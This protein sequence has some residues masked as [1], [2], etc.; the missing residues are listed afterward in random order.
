MALALDD[1]LPFYPE[2]DD[3]LLQRTLWQKKEFHDFRVGQMEQKIEGKRKLDQQVLTERFFSDVA[4]Y[5]EGLIYHE[6]GTGKTWSAFALAESL[7]QRKNFKQCI[8]LARGDDSL[9]NLRR[10]LVTTGNSTYVLATDKRTMEEEMRQIRRIVKDFYVF[11]TYYAFGKELS[12]MPDDTIK[13]KY[14]NT[15]FVIDEVHN[16]RPA[17]NSAIYK[18][19]H[20][21]FHLV[22]RRKILLMS[23]T[24]MRDD[25]GEIADIMNLILPEDKQL[26][27]GALFRAEFLEEQKDGTFMPRKEKIS[28]LKE[29][30]RG[31]ISYMSSALTNVAI[32][33]EGVSELPDIPQFRS[34]D[35]RMSKHQSDAYQNAYS[36]DTKGEERSIYTN[37]LQASLFVFPDGSWGTEGTGTFMKENGTLREDFAEQLRTNLQD[38]SAKYH[39]IIQT[40]KNP[41]NRHKNVYIYCS[42]VN[43]S[44][45]NLLA[46]ILELYGYRRCE[47]TEQGKARRYLLLTSQTKN[48]TRKIAYFNREQN[49]NG[50]YCHVIVGSRKIAEVFSF[51]NVQIE[52]LETLHWNETETSQASRRAARVGSWDALLAVTPNVSLS[53]SKVCA[54]P[55]KDSDVSID[56]LMLEI[57]KR[58]DISIKRIDRIIK[59]V[60][61]DCPLMYER[62]VHLESGDYSR[63]CD[64][65]V[66]VYKCDAG[67]CG[68]NGPETGGQDFST[69]ELYYDDYFGLIDPI[70][71]LFEQ[72]DSL[73][74]QALTDIVRPVEHIQILKALTFIIENNLVILNR[75]KT[76][77]YLR[78]R[79]DLYYLVTSLTSNVSSLEHPVFTREESLDGF[80][81]ELSRAKSVD[82]LKELRNG[83]D[84]TAALNQLPGSTA[85]LLVQLAIKESLLNNN[86]SQQV[87]KVLTHYDKSF[88][89]YRSVQ[90]YLAIF[91]DHNEVTWCLKPD[92]EWALCVAQI[93]RQAPPSDSQVGYEGILGEEGKFCIRST[94]QDEKM[95]DKR[96]LKTGAVCIEAGWKRSKLLEIMQELSIPQTDNVPFAKMSKKEICSTLQDW[97]KQ[98]GLLHKGK[99]GTARKKRV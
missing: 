38:Y 55:Q 26:P 10:E 56:K 5:D 52:L 69:Y 29:Y 35:L 30:L 25:V 77:C 93:P 89:I 36:Q 19:L 40:V 16:V 54:I 83:R 49:K 80:I 59:E 75:Y 97:F 11:K 33:R 64:Y 91:Q 4:P 96:K 47:G 6:M 88:H 85:D 21:A 81:E 31:R 67:D 17:D 2:V 8:V 94:Q 95:A 12:G 32:I 57:S 34:V 43:G 87:E 13:S 3:P 70:V 62:N 92:G 68:Q 1:F 63:E 28:L 74:F 22:S 71:K 66:C 84:V 82:A 72:R 46:R 86:R 73:S 37:S 90:E 58:K 79:Q 76:K 41:R 42:L 23:G 45:V 27:T 51:K 18:Q 24:P 50:D 48:I 53:I 9:D 15:L 98:K 60:A 65:D 39:H 44:G 20:R 61:Y 14:E 99:C 78:E 7:K